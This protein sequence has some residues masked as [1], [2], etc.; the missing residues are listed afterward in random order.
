MRRAGLVPEFHR[1]FIPGG[2]YF[3]TVVT[4]ERAP[5]FRSEEACSLLG[6][7]L[8]DAIHDRPFRVTAIVL[9]P[10][11]LHMIWNLPAGD[12]DFSSRMASIKARFTREWLSQGGAENRVPQGQARQRRRGIWQARFMEHA[13][14]DADDFTHHLDYLHYNPIKHGLVRC[15]TE[16]P[17][18]SFHRY[19]R[20]GDYPAD[21]ACSQGGEVPAFGTVQETLIE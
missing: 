13:I 5:I 15:P 8:R 19:V 14:R 20:L 12:P 16:W 18:S 11:H 4:A 3:F 17:Y 7:C 9:L 1:Y 21:W 10:D 6:N 2:T